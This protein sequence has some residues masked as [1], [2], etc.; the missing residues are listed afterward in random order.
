MSNLT[1]PETLFERRYG[2]N[3][4]V[5]VLGPQRRRSSRPACT[6]CR[7]GAAPCFGDDT[8]VCTPLKRLG[9]IVL[10]VGK[11]SRYRLKE[12][13]L[14]TSWW[15]V[16][17]DVVLGLWALRRCSWNPTDTEL[18]RFRRSTNAILRSEEDTMEWAE[19]RLGRAETIATFGWVEPRRSL[20]RTPR[21]NAMTT[22][23]TS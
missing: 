21:T 22:T 8:R 10:T 1:R 20:R 14:A 9:S 19:S 18:K 13:H 15:R 11:G 12:T 7:V 23:D 4:N 6:T 3:C 16:I 2:A 5:T 17:C